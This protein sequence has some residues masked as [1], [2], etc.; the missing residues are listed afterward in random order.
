MEI[1]E[2]TSTTQEISEDLGKSVKI[3]ENLGKLA[4]FK[5]MNFANP[6]YVT[7]ID[8][9]WALVR[10]KFCKCQLE[11]TCFQWVRGLS[12]ALGGY[13]GNLLSC[14][15]SCFLCKR[16]NFK[17]FQTFSWSNSNSPRNMRPNRLLGS[18]W[19]PLGEVKNVASK[20]SKLKSRISSLTIIKARVTGMNGYAY[21]NCL[22]VLS[23]NTCLHV[24]R[25]HQTWLSQGLSFLGP[26][27]PWALS[28]LQIVKFEFEIRRRVASPNFKFEFE[29]LKRA[30]LDSTGAPWGALGRKC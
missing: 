20:F 3:Y 2:N 27:G 7:F 15:I 29:N 17:Y 4:V 5:S 16:I 26:P 30:P 19:D 1:Q 24:L 18:P 22:Q 23:S 9:S 25:G 28:K 11:H 13:G 21:Y 6:K 14:L 12:Y 10:H 8:V